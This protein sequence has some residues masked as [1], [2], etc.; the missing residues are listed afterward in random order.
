MNQSKRRK[1]QPQAKSDTFSSFPIT[2][3]PLHLILYN[4]RQSSREPPFVLLLESA[5]RWC[6]LSSSW[7]ATRHTIIRLAQ[8]SAFSITFKGGGAMRSSTRLSPGFITNTCCHTRTQSTHVFS[9][10]HNSC[11]SNDSCIFL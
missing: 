6:H 9:Y 1:K 4:T 7:T 11:T 8:S 10:S 2:M 5:C 3:R